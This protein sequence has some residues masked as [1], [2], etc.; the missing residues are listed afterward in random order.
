VRYPNLTPVGPLMGWTR[1][2]TVTETTLVRNQPFT[3][4]AAP[5][6]VCTK[7]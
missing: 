3:S 7:P 4:R 6:V 1:T 2:R 5:T